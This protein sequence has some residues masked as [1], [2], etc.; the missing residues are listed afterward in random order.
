MFH[1]ALTL[2]ALAAVLAVAWRYLG[3]YMAAVYGGRV[4]WLGFV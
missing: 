3:S 1:F 4:K 2:V